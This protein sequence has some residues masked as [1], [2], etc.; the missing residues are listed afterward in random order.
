MSS[1]TARGTWE[2]NLPVFSSVNIVICTSSKNVQ[3]AGVA[4]A[5]VQKNVLARQSFIVNDNVRAATL[6]AFNV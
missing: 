1:K 3:L 4:E 5:S 6:N 2:D